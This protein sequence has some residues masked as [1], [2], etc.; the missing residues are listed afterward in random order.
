M[1]YMRTVWIERLLGSRNRS[2]RTEA[3]EIKAQELVQAFK[4]GFSRQ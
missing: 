4:E 3:Q 2:S 1:W